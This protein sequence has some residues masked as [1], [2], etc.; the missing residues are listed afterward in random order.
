MQV[1]HI[2][3]IED[4]PGDTLIFREIVLRSRLQ[5]SEVYE[6]VS[7]AEGLKL[8]QEV[9]VEIVFLDL[10]LPDNVGLEAILKIRET[11]SSV[12]VIV[13]TGNDDLNLSMEALNL[14]AQDYLVKNDFDEKML[15]RSVI[16]SIQRKKYDEQITASEEKYRFLFQNNPVPM[17]MF[18]EATLKIIKVNDAAVD[19]Y[20]FTEAEFTGLNISD[21]RPQEDLQ[22]LKEALKVHRDRQST[23]YEVGIW[24]H[25]RK[26][27]TVLFV[28]LFINPIVYDGKNVKLVAVYDVTERQVAR[29]QRDSFFE[30]SIDLMYVGDMEG[31]LVQLNPRWAEV[32]GYSLEEIRSA[33]VLHFTHPDDHQRIIERFAHAIQN[34][35]RMLSTDSRLIAKDGREVYMNWNTSIDIE[36][37]IMFSIGRDVT[38][39]RAEEEQLRLL[40]SAVE[41]T[42]E[43]VMM[44][45]IMPSA[46]DGQ[47]IIY[48][49]GAL[50]RLTGYSREEIIGN[51]PWMFQGAKTNRKQLE[52]IKKFMERF[53]PVEAELINYTRDGREFWMHMNMMPVADNSGKYRNWV[54]I[55]R[56]ITEWK[57]TELERKKQNELLE[58]LVL[59]RTTELEAVNKDLEAF[60]YS[61]SHDLRTP[62]RAIDIY[63]GLLNEELTGTECHGYVHQINKCVDEMRN[64]I[65]DL[66]E[67]SKMGK[68]PL[69]K[70]WVEMKDMIEEVFFNQ[71]VSENVPNAQLV[72]QNSPQVYGDKKLLRIVLNNLLSNAVKYS[73]HRE[74]PVIKVSGWPEDTGIV[75][76]IEDNGIGFDPKHSAKLFKPFSR[77]H[78]GETYKG[79]GAGLAIVD[80]IINRHGGEIWAESVPDV[81]ASF[82]LRLPVPPKQA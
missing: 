12:P 39:K 71:S 3:I 41:N 75:Y 43:A 46:E 34:R 82:Y 58:R 18:D 64:L 7:L 20:Q 11:K 76:C 80:K 45:E 47:R 26:D 42:T 17:Y 60:N 23:Y 62:L 51:S 30:L 59:N 67:F 22:R 78:S 1:K 13:M 81:G 70:E 31:N 35:E 52:R 57:N 61:V 72:I 19:L 53:E 79:N 9:P 54:S 32:L 68:T 73:S 37:N 69:E 49:N 55:Q 27:G 6:A 63:A 48:A 77:L 65:D 4:N 29:K 10:G 50:S 44:T 2:L 66:L 14:G 38:E 21:L 24:R 16:Y 28:D 15:E 25:R 40:Q 8:L 36:N 56:D 5:Y 74:S 33:T